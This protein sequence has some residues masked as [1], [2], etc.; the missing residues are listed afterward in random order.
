[1]SAEQFFQVVL[2]PQGDFARFLRAETAERERLLEKLFGTQRFADVEHWFRTAR[3][4]RGR[5]VE[6][7]RQDVRELLARVGQA[8]GVD[9][10][11]EAPA[12]IGW[13]AT[14]HARLRGA[15][16]DAAKEDRLAREDRVRAEQELV[17]RRG[18]A[19]RIRRV[20]TAL[21]TLAELDSGAEV[22]RQLAEELSAA[23][24]CQPV[25]AAATAARRAAADLEAAARTER[26]AMA[27]LTGHAETSADVSTLRALAG[28]L[29][30]EA[31]SLRHLVM[32]AETQQ[33]DQTRLANLASQHQRG[34]ARLVDLAEQL[35]NLPQRLVAAH[36]QRDA[37]MTARNRLDGLR[38]Q[39]VE[40]RALH[41]DATTLP[42]VRATHSRR[43]AEAAAA[44]DAHQHAREALLDARQRRLDGMSA[45]LA[46]ALT[47]DHP[48]PVCGSAEHPTPAVPSTEPVGHAEENA[49]A[50]A[51][52]TAN[53]NRQRTAL[54][55]AEASYQ[56]E[57][58]TAR[59]ANRTEPDLAE[60]LDAA[61]EHD[62]EGYLPQASELSEWTG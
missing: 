7:I 44:V 20:T 55:A 9:P 41:A 56:L 47:P 30:E 49:V 48:C 15:A 12:D 42:A 38:A 17:H 43:Q 28:A 45:E 59:L 60:E 50:E 34:D 23:H 24:R 35:A 25:L 19:E 52:H 62:G 26:Q 6:E 11:D 53:A 36:A 16:V 1:M 37:A 46:G 51:E 3:A 27:A 2:L 22:R 54:A 33:T 32:E 4:E 18:L 5:A 8:A 57:A 29:R 14:L 40:L 21:A 31:G 39:V 61:E 13:L 10:D 58:L